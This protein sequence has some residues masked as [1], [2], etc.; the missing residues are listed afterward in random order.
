[1]AHLLKYDSVMG[2]LDAD[3]KATDDGGIR[4]TATS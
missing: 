2:T 3:V 4:S 1:M